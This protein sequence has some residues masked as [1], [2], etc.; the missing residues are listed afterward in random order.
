MPSSSRAPRVARLFRERR[1]LLIAIVVLVVAA[2]AGAALTSAT[3]EARRNALAP[4][5]WRG[6]R[7]GAS[8]GPEMR[9]RLQR[10]GHAQVVD[11]PRGEVGRQDRDE[12]RQNRNGRR[13]LCF[14]PTGA[15]N[16]S[17]PATWET[18]G[19]WGIRV[20]FETS[21]LILRARKSDVFLRDPVWDHPR[22]TECGGSGKTWSFERVG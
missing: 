10:D 4:V 8:T 12:A 17:G 2:L 18:V 9:V 3:D 1:G 21:S 20:R 5:E 16:Y 22:M 13:H 19:E 14:A 11:A 15:G 7:D 6:I